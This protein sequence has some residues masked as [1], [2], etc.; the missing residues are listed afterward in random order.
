M[1]AAVPSSFFTTVLDNIGL[2]A[3]LGDCETA[4]GCGVVVGSVFSFDGDDDDDRL[5]RRLDTSLLSSAAKSGVFTLTCP[6][7][8]NENGLYNENP[9][10]KIASLA[11]TRQIR[12]K[13]RG[14][15][16]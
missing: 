9:T 10:D 7:I 15:S 16:I 5:R 1:D 12:L 11:R 2:D 14:I 8:L 6:R 3:G 4:A 13:N